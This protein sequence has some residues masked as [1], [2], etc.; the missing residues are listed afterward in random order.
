MSSRTSEAVRKPAVLVLTPALT[1][2]SWISIQRSLSALIDRGWAVR[3]VGLGPAR[4]VDSRLSV[5][6]VPFPRYDR[7]GWLT[8]KSNLIGFLWNLPLLVLGLV[9]TYKCRPRIV[10]HNGLT[11]A[12]TLGPLVKRL[13]CKSVVMYHGYVDR[14]AWDG[15]L[16]KRAAAAIDLA[17]VNSPG[18]RKNLSG[19]LP[20]DRIVIS[21]H[22][23]DAALF[24]T[25]LERP[26]CEAPLTVLYVGRLD[27]VKLCDALIRA[28]ADSRTRGVRFLFVGVG[29]FQ[30]DVADVA[31]ANPE[32]EYLGY[33]SDRA[34]LLALYAK[35]D[36]VWSYADD[37]YLAL[38]AVEALAAG[39][40]VIVPRL[41]AI[42][43]KAAR[44]VTVDES[45][46]PAGVGW[47]VDSDDHENVID[48]LLRL[49]REGV[50]AE[51]RAAARACAAERYSPRNLVSTVNAIVRLRDGE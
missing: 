28:A 25:D 34:E 48:L 13:G 36:V 4:G 26:D 16:T 5:R 7:H 33:V 23:A 3:V 39:R 10:M 1:G 31:A 29:A 2:G 12:L 40:P 43:E 6:A 24:E 35:A 38:P 50:P 46:V 14:S 21:E 47:F 32:V 19:L 30:Q 51:M 49:R 8:T 42:E 9:L 45:L 11:S 15:T 41:V 27:P 18:S 44:G 37:S 17:V 22:Y 20:E